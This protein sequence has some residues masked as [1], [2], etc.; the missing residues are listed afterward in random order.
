MRTLVGTILIALALIA[1]G[2][3]HFR[4]EM[5]TYREAF[6]Y[7]Y[8]PYEFTRSIQE[9]SAQRETNDGLFHGREYPQLKS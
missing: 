8:G 9:L 4:S 7:S 6:L 1:L 2:M 5:P 3:M